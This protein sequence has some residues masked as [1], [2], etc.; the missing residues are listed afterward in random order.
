MS[1][2][3]FLKPKKNT[4][5]VAKD[6]LADAEFHDFLP[7]V[8]FDGMIEPGA[9]ISTAFTARKHRLIMHHVRYSDI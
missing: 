1:I 7:G 6:R 4:A 3:D 5:A 9:T 8:V 2:F